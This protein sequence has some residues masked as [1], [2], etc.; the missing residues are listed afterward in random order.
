MNLLSRPKKGGEKWKTKGRK[1]KKPL[2]GTRENHKMTRGSVLSRIVFN[3]CG[4]LHGVELCRNYM[5]IVFLVSRGSSEGQHDTWKQNHGS[6]AE[7]TLHLHHASPS[8]EKLVSTLVELLLLLP[9]A[10][11]YAGKQRPART[12]CR[13]HMN[14]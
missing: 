2:A 8:L 10:H 7:W 9:H 11:L 5:W 6:M 3:N 1:Q 13:L 12:E 14:L 4:N